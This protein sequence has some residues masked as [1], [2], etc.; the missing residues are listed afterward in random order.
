M[1]GGPHEAEG[2]MFES[3]EGSGRAQ[4]GVRPANSWLTRNSG[5]GK[6]GPGNFRRIGQVQYP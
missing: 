4:L 2:I 5:R 3:E 6:P 1:F